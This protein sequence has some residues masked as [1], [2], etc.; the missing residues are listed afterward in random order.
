MRAVGWHLVHR[1]SSNRCIAA[2]ARAALVMMPGWRRKGVARG[3]C[4][5]QEGAYRKGGGARGAR[6]KRQQCD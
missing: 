5:E 2:P 1:V 3:G 6:A 4:T